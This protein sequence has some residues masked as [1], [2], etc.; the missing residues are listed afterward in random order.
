MAARL[1]GVGELLALLPWPVR[2]VLVPAAIARGLCAVGADGR[3]AYERALARLRYAISAQHVVVF[4]RRRP[5]A[6]ERL[7]DVA[8]GADE[9]GTSLRPGV[10]R[11]GGSVLIARPARGRQR[12]RRVQL[13]ATEDRWLTQPRELELPLGA[14][15]E[16]R[17][18][19]R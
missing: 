19:R 7:N 14:R 10:V 18:A 16:I 17:C 9:H 11:G 5:R 2:L 12:R 3:P 4:Q 15:L 1:P 6:V 13:T 8:V